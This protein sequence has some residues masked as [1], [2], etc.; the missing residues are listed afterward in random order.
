VESLEGRSLVCA[1]TTDVNFVHDRFGQG[2]LDS[3]VELDIEAEVI[4]SGI[5]ARFCG[6]SL[7]LAAG[8][9]GQAT[10]EDIRKVLS[11]FS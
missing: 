3:M 5:Q 8:T 9:V 4:R 11:V 10:V 2:V 6:F 1:V 7:L